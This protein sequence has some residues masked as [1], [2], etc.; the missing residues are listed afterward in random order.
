MRLQKNCPKCGLQKTIYKYSDR[1]KYV[2]LPCRPKI[3]HS[4]ATK[5]KNKIYKRNKRKTDPL[6]KAK[7]SIYRYK[8][9]QYRWKNDINFRLVKNI[10]SRLSH[11]IKRNTKSGKTLELL[12]CPIEDFK[13]YLES[14]FQKDMNWD[15][16]GEWHVDHIKALKYFNLTETEQL[17]IASH[18]TNLQPLWAIDNIR[19]DNAKKV[20][21]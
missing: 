20:L 15:N 12:G 14:K 10:R 7:E 8:Y 19:K 5:E 6:Y 9:E 16:Y 3:V 1:N 18:Y 13:K 17:K 4:E 2:C 21:S 11:A